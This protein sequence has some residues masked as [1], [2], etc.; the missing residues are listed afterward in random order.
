MATSAY[1]WW[2]VMEAA[3]AGRQLPPGVAQD[4]AGAPTTDPQAV[5]SGGALLSF[6]RTHKGSAL[7]LIV[8]LL[9]GPLAGAAIA[10]KKA[11]RNWGNLIVAVDP[12]LLGPADEFRSRV[13]DVLRR[14]KEARRQ[15]GAL[16]RRHTA[17]SCARISIV[18]LLTTVS[19]HANSQGCRRSFCP[20]SAAIGSQERAC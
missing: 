1:A 2:G 12:E 16:R 10:E 20:G 14:V 19:S 18:I 5:L 17:R 13:G 7:G 4:A 9:A 6:D 15:P 8:E 3:T 11:A